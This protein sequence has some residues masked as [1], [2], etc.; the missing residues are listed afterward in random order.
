MASRLKTVIA[1]HTSVKNGEEEAGWSRQRESHV[2]YEKEEETNYS[3][4]LRKLQTG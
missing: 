1:M 4:I 2:V 3:T